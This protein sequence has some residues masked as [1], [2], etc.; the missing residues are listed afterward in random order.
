MSDTQ[1]TQQ[2]LT[3]APTIAALPSTPPTPFTGVK[4]DNHQTLID[5]V[6][7]IVDHVGEVIR[8]DFNH[9]E[10]D[11]RLALHKIHEGYL[12]ALRHVGILPPKA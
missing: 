1:T 4:S 2:I 10:E 3:P 7:G 8:N 12:S 11:V 5:R 9:L 6:E